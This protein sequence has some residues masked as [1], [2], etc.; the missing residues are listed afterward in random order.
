MVNS[1]KL[2]VYTCITGGYD[3]PMD[4]NRNQPDG[5][6]FICFTDNPDSL[7]GTG[8]KAKPIPEE[9]LKF[10]KVKQQRLI[11]VLPH[12]YLPDY[13]SSLWI[14]GN[15][16]VLCNVGDYLKDYPLDRLSFYT[17]K[18]PSRDCIYKEGLAVVAIKRDTA[19]NVFPQIHKYQQEGFPEHF[20]LHETNMVYRNHRSTECRLLCNM[21]ATEIIRQSHR[22]QLSLDYC[23]WKSGVEIGTLLTDRIDIDN[24]FRWTRHG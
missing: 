6:D 7:S 4:F 3:K 18:H 17:R 19:E 16:Q 11:K 5:V 24:N 12:R 8:W 2:C 10:S 20:G 13:D 14:D 21:W 15:M 1:S 22:D 9:L 23:R